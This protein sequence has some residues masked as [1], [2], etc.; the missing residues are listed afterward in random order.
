ME[1]VTSHHIH[2]CPRCEC[3]YANF[4]ELEEHLRDDHGIEGLQPIP[5]TLHMLWSVPKRDPR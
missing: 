3:R 1:E 4:W 2:Q 5:E